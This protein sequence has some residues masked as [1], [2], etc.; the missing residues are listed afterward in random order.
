[1]EKKEFSITIKWFVYKDVSPFLRHYNVTNRNG[2][3]FSDK[4]GYAPR[5]M[6][7]ILLDVV[8][9]Y[10]FQEATKFYRFTLKIY[11]KTNYQ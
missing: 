8:S 2:W 4:K 3:D 6:R 5:Q 1:M 7:I 11:F 10:F 9:I